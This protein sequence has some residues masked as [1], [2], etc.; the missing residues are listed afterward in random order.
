MS[1]IDQ[2]VDDCTVSENGTGVRYIHIYDNKMPEAIRKRVRESP[3]NLCCACLHGFCMDFW[4]AS[5]HNRENAWQLAI[6]A[7][8][9]K[10]RARQSEEYN[11]VQRHD[12]KT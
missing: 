6:D 10:I 3:F 8:E 5:E 12:K 2:A 7:M 4:P 11:A 9:R 1:N